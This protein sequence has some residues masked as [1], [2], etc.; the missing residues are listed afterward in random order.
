MPLDPLGNIIFS[1]GKSD[2]SKSP[3]LQDF[4][5]IE[6]KDPKKTPDSLAS[7]LSSA[8]AGVRSWAIPTS[9]HD[10]ASQLGPESTPPQR[11]GPASSTSISRPLNA[12]IPIRVLNSP[13]RFSDEMM[14]RTAK[15]KTKYVLAY[16]PPITRSKRRLS[17]RPR[18]ML[19]LQR[20]S[21]SIR[22]LPA[23]DVVSSTAFASRLTRSVPGIAKAEKCSGINDLLLV[24]SDTYEQDQ[25]ADDNVIDESGDESIHHHDVV[26]TICYAKHAK[27]GSTN[28]DQIC[29]ENG[30]IWEAYCLKA[31]IY[32]F[33]GKNHDSLKLRWVLRKSP[34]ADQGKFTRFTFSIINPDTRRHPVIA[35]LTRDNKLDIL[36]RFSPSISSVTASPSSSTLQSPLLSEFSS[37]TSYFN[38]S[39]GG[40]LS[41]IE[42]DENLRML[43]M[44]TGIWVMSEEGWSDMFPKSSGVMK[45]PREDHTSRSAS[46]MVSSTESIPKGS[47]QEPPKS[48]RLQQVSA[49]PSRRWTGCL[50]SPSH[51]RASSSRRL[52][53]RRET[54]DASQR[55]ED[56]APIAK[57]A[58]CCGQEEAGSSTS[59]EISR[60][61][62]RAV[63]LNLGNVNDSKTRQETTLFVESEGRPQALAKTPTS[64]LEQHASEG[65]PVD[66]EVEKER[67]EVDE[68]RRQQRKW[69]KIRA[70]CKSLAGPCITPT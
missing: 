37:E 16:P 12:S 19:Q 39:I 15:T 43:I 48:Y 63:P 26:G 59:T 10:L 70:A 51:V 68:R 58:S 20:V 1:L 35:T 56:T 36:D 22:P 31:D 50:D 33:S 67:S 3:L 64:I 46:T 54:I 13:G 65:R 49:S 61:P 55:L 28:R 27:D 4:G 53:L 34:K 11:P 6:D 60:R 41:Y 29:L 42:T 40:G 30:L 62:V 7:I 47:P 14:T 57:S 21:N 44:L 25:I 32:E 9:A 24:R 66:L 18:M 8:I 45:R 17:V 52:R 69:E 5:S 23:F 38:H 2:Q